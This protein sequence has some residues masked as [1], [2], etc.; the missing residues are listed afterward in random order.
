MILRESICALHQVGTALSAVGLPIFQLFLSLL[1]TRNFNQLAVR[2]P[3]LLRPNTR[4]A[5]LRSWLA[6]WS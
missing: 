3:D 5:D 6:D 4:I 1:H 2:L